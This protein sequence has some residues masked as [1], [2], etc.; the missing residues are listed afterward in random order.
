M[1]QT[2][3]LI[4]TAGITSLACVTCA[5]ALLWHNRK[6]WGWFL[7]AALLIALTVSTSI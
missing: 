5:V 3:W 7:F 6:G 2:Y 1:N 4:V